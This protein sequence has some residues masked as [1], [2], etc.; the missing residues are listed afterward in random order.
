MTSPPSATPHVPV[1]AINPTVTG[2]I[3]INPVDVPPITSLRA[4]IG[5]DTQYLSEVV[6]GDTTS[7]KWIAATTDF[8]VATINKTTNGVVQQTTIP[9]G[10]KVANAAEGVVEVAFS[11]HIKDIIA[12]YLPQLPDCNPL[13]G[14]DEDTSSAN[15]ERR[16]RIH[17]QRADVAA[18]CTRR[19]GGR[20]GQLLGEDMEWG[21]QAADLDM[22][23]ASASGTDAG[24]LV[25]GEQTLAL[26]EEDAVA[27]MIINEMAIS[28]E[29]E[30]IEVTL[31][32]FFF[33]I[34]VSVAI[35]FAVYEVADTLWKILATPKT[36]DIFEPT[37]T[38]DVSAAPSSVVTP[39][40]CP[41]YALPCVGDSC[42]GSPDGTCSSGDFPGCPCAVSGSS[43][44]DQTFWED[45]FGP[46]E[47]LIADY[48]IPQPYV[49]VCVKDA[50]D[51]PE[52]FD[53]GTWSSMFD[54]FCSKIHE[55]LSTD[56][57][58]CVTSPTQDIHFSFDGNSTDGC[59]DQC[60][61]V[62]DKLR[63]G[64]T[65]DSYR[66]YNVG[67]MEVACGVAMY[68]IGACQDETST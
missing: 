10:F 66:K 8:G 60:H 20:L 34:T 22:Q 7:T 13:P 16:P 32:S 37:R 61:D 48:Q 5:D 49:P 56:Q 33:E 55:P 11:P 38:Y 1:D 12:K 58:Q 9:K 3:G 54:T 57:D 21:E 47:D 27:E 35:L 43:I 14:R 25:E 23:L 28:A 44:G 63:D 15:T 59:T 53:N 36:M 46:V 6:Y 50:T 30:L 39:S 52:P 17:Q 26:M 2:Q 45:N 64:C 4:S 18:S 19:R 51:D 41:T 65:Y 67:F 68:T 40:S 24:A 62:F 42:Q 31:G 29:M